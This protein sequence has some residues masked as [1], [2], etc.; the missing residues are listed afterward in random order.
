MCR[1]SIGETRQRRY[2]A[3]VVIDCGGDDDVYELA[4][5]ETLFSWRHGQTLRHNTVRIQMHN[6]F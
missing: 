6:H 2:R 5:G 4:P 1:S 3:N